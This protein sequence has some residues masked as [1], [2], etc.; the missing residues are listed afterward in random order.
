MQPRQIGFLVDLSRCVGCGACEMACQHNHPD[1][2]RGFRHMQKWS[3][4][5]R[6]QAFLSM[7]CN[8]CGSPE[9]MR[10]CPFGCYEKKRDGVVTH[11]SAKCI[12]CGR[13][14]GACPFQAPRI[15]PLTGKVAKCDLCY[16]RLQAGKQPLCVEACPME[17]LKLCDVGTQVVDWQDYP[18]VRYTQP[19]IRFIKARQPLCFWREDR[20][21]AADQE[22][23]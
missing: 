5:H 18:L 4:S 15:L 7:A 20:I 10:V 8:H 17:A 11:N 16:E 22:D 9:C 21:N 12:G 2:P 3:G 14:V 6:E 1:S 13:C 19:S 23:N